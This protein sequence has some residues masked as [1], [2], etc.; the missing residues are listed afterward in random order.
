MVLLAGGFL[1]YRANAAISDAYRWTA[2]AEASS[3][4]RAYAFALTPAGPGERR[5]GCASARRA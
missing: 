3:I 2:E 4:A 1:T 5:R